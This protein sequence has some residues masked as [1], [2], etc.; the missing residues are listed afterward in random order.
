M[1][2]YNKACPVSGLKWHCGK[3]V[4]YYFQN[5]LYIIRERENALW[6][7]ETYIM[8]QFYPED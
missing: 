1:S 6:F 7:K 8:N 5:G 3:V 4:I 2:Q